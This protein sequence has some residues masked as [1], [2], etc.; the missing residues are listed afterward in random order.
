MEIV[1]VTYLGSNPQYQEYSN[2]DLTLVNKALITPTYG[3]PTDYIE[4]FIKNQSGEVIGSNYNLSKYNIGSDINPQ[5]GN[6]SVLYLN[7]EIDAR[8]QGFNRGSVNVKYNFFRKFILSGPNPSTNFWIKEVSTS[9]TEIK[10]ARQDLSNSELSTAFN[11][12]NNELGQDAYY[13]DFLL[14]FGL[15]IQI[16]AVNAV[17]VEEEGQGYVIF[18]LY[19]PLPDEFDVKSTFWVVY[20]VAEPA[21]FNV[22]INVTPELLPTSFPLRGP[23]YKVNITDKIGKT[24]PYYNYASLFLTSV[25][26]SY[27]QLKSM[28]DEKGIQ[29]NVDY[30]NFNNFIHFSS[31]TERLY[32]FTYKIQQI[33]SASAALAETNTSSSRITTQSEIDNIITKFDGYE[34]YLY[35][36]SASTAWPKTSTTQPYP[37]YSATSSQ[38]VN[39]LGNLN[40]I[41]NGDATMSMYFSASEYDNNNKDWLQYTTPAYIREDSNNTPYLVFLDM[42]GQH[43]D[44]IWI[45]LKDLSNRYSAEN[46]PFV[47]I[48]MDQVGD[49]LKSFGIN[50]YTNTNVSDNIYYSMLGINQTGSSLPIT[51][52][53]YSTVVIE[54]SSLFPAYY[55]D[56][57]YWANPSL[58]TWGSANFSWS[59]NPTPNDYLSSS[60]FLPPFGQEKIKQYVTTFVTASAGVTSSFATLPAE[61][62]KNEIYKRLYHNLAYLLKTK[63]TDRGVKALITTY[64]IPEDILAVNEYGGYNIYDIAGIQELNN[65]NITTG[66]VLNI[67]SSL[68]SPYTTLQYYQNDFD[69]TS[70]DV[71]VGFSPADAINAAITS[72]GIVTASNEPGYFNIMQYIGAPNLQYSSSYIPLVELENTFFSASFTGNSQTSLQRFNVWD[73]IRTIKYYNNSLFKMVRDFVPARA[74]LASGIIVKS[75]ILERNKYARHEP[76]VTFEDREGDIQMVTVT[77]SDPDVIRYSTG[78]TASI[79]VQYS[80]ASNFL[81]TASGYVIQPSSYGI[82]KYNGEFSGSIIQAS[83]N[84]FPQLGVSSYIYPWTSSVAPSQHG[85][86]NKMFLTYP[87]NYLT[88]NVT[89][90][91]ISQRFLDLDYSSNQIVPVNYGLITQSLLDTEAFGTTYVSQQPYSQYAQVQDYNYALKRSVLPRYSGSILSGLVYNQFTSQSVSYSGDISYGD[92]PVI[93]YYSDKLGYFVQIES[94]SFIPGKVNASL[95]YFA[96][97]SG[98]LFELNQNNNNWQDLQNIFVGGETLTIKQFDNQKFS[99][100]VATDGIKSIYNSGY[101]YTPQLYYNSASDGRI[102]FSYQTGS[103]VGSFTATN[104]SNFFISGAASPR[105]LAN[106]TNGFIYNI[107][108]LETADSVNY[109]SPGT[110]SLQ[111]FPTFSSPTAGTRTFTANMSVN[112]EFPTAG[113]QATYSLVLTKNNTP[114][115]GGSVTAGFA[116]IASGGTTSFG[117]VSTISPDQYVLTFTT[118]SL[119]P[120]VTSGPFEVFVNGASQGVKGAAD[121]KIFWKLFYYTYQATPTQT[122]SEDGYF[123]TAIYDTNNELQ[124]YID[125]LTSTYSYGTPLTQIIATGSTSGTS[126]LSS[127]LNLSVN[128]AADSYNANDIISVKVKQQV[129]AS[130][131]NFTASV[132][133]GTFT[134]SETAQ[135]GGYP[136]VTTA[137]A[138]F[139]TGLSNPTSQTGLITFSS[140]ISAYYGY[141]QVPYFV[142]GGT[143]YYNSLYSQYGDVNANFY[144]QQNDKIILQDY[145]GVYQD[146][147]VFTSS[148]NSSGV[149]T[150]TTVPGINTDWVAN[151][152]LLYNVLVLSRYKDEQNVILTFNKNPGQTSYGFLIPNTVSPDITNNINTLQAAVQ[153][154]VLT[155][156]SAPSIDTI[157]GGTFN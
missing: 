53:E 127:T 157:N 122:V 103:V 90:S 17:Y 92:D 39:W 72:S 120:N 22:T 59:F 26:S 74:N 11:I 76:T 106:P 138:A 12:F 124:F 102:Y 69:K 100:Q 73:F 38:V 86:A 65:D 152:K 71:E 99:N 139:I 23:N 89:G 151:P 33:E 141:Q 119:S 10:C 52:S 43:F 36:S 35:F 97:V 118:F 105:Y 46:N 34:Y 44:N 25:T 121:S 60:L 70:A 75:H 83:Y 81:A 47:G 24:T 82:E 3:G 134:F 143:T 101:N 114:I 4:M 112:V 140:A 98:G 30:S 109:Y 104:Q 123:A 135:Q 78:Y 40:T 6:T 95:A 142:S 29:I 147:N 79:R 2:S 67:S 130:G 15:D 54:S 154:Q 144:P 66:S 57:Y 37:L 107:F 153:S 19:E 126:V 42:I 149:V 155:N 27:Q 137:S 20:Q 85:G 129:T 45:Y 55:V 94:S 111:F 136:F 31:I 93:N 32:N 116:S 16:I 115:N 7:P 131:Q 9:R 14:N 108:D 48:S 63:G 132:T 41:P 156:Q 150:I 5:N 125:T 148:I 28:M 50:L 1:D 8:D 13:P 128:T 56:P 91:V 87:L 64:G 58:P 110:A 77:G 96:D 88:N 146:L 145:R 18:K 117:R 84:Y 61:Q 80:S 68:L 62:L 21:E 49:A 51:S 133:A 113:Q